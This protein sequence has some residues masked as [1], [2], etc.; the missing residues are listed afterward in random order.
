MEDSLGLAELHF[1]ASRLPNGH[2]TTG[3][4]GLECRPVFLSNHVVLEGDITVLKHHADATGAS[5]EAEVGK[6]TS[7]HV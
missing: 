5:V 6:F 3:H 7:A 4:G 2:G 1:G